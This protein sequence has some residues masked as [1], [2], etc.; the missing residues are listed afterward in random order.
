[1][2]RI[3]AQITA[4]REAQGISETRLADNAAIPRTTFKR[5]L[6]DPDSFTLAELER[7]AGA[8]GTDPAG[9]WLGDAA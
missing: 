7:V 3:A 1:M 6:I 9:L 4:L 2:E 8:L 5:R